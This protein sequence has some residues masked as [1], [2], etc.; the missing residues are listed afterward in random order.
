MDI[1]ATLSLI[2]H[3][4]DAALWQAHVTAVTQIM[5]SDPAREEYRELEVLAD[6]IYVEC[7]TRGFF[8]TTSTLF[9]GLIPPMD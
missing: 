1:H 7:S 6:A 4:T 5:L 2:P 3:L 8:D 9:D